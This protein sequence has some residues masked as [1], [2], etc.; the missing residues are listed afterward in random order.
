MNPQYIFSLVQ[1]APGR[2]IFIN[3]LIPFVFVFISTIILGAILTPILRKMR[4]EQVIRDDGPQSHLK[5][6]GT[7][8]MGGLIFLIPISL[9]GILFPFI[10]SIKISG[11]II[12]INEFLRIGRGL[13]LLSAISLFILLVGVVGFVDDFTKIRID[14]KGL[15]PTRKSVYLL[16]VIVLFTVYYIYLS[17]IEPH[18][19]HPF[20]TFITGG[21]P[22]PITGYWKFIYALFTI[23]VLYV[24]SN[25]VNMTDGID[26]LASSVTAIAALFL[27]IIG[28][29]LNAQTARTA[30]MLSFALAAG[31]VAFFL[32]N[33][34]PAKIMMGDTGSQALGAGIS[35]AAVVMGMVWVL[36]FIGI[37]YVLESLSVV[38]Q[39][40]YFKRTR[41][42]I[43][44]MAPLHHHFELTGWSEWKIVRVF[45]LLTLCFCFITFLIVSKG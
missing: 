25:S 11:T 38:I 32:F 9:F 17:G 2:M 16:I 36:P 45:F 35:A 23:F 1:I 18:I 8:T 27:G 15:S 10:R 37:V 44:R 19:Y 14:K 39:V 41:R 13:P 24:T 31:C 3:A 4:A 28:S 29:Y 5:K 40:A 21:I 33:K 12:E 34:H 22:I 6:S 20:S 26:G 43:F 42:R 7:P 30:S